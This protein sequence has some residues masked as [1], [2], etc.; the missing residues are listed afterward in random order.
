MKSKLNYMCS[1]P[2]W[3]IALHA[4]DS[5]YLGRKQNEENGKKDPAEKNKTAEEKST[6]NKEEGRER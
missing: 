1:L 5:D 3:K 6:L 2:Y 4:G